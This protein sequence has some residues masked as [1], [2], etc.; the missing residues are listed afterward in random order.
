MK[1]FFDQGTPVPLRHGLKG[2]TVSTAYEL[3]WNE[4]DNGK[5]LKAAEVEFDVFVTTDKN[6]RHQQQLTGRHLAIVVL[7]TT[8]WPQLRVHEAEIVAMI[9]TLRPGDVVEMKI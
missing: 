5:L 4:L 1:I 3:G 8:N 6:L 2:H 9:D 7:P